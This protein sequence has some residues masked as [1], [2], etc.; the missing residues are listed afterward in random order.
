V[1]EDDR[2]HFPLYQAVIL[3][4][5]DLAQRAPEAVRAIERIEGKID[6]S[7]MIAMNAR[8]K[9]QK[10]SDVRVAQRFPRR[11]SVGWRRRQRAWVLGPIWDRTRTFGIGRVSLLA[12]ILCGGS[13]GVLAAQS[14][15]AGHVIMGIVAVRLHDSLAGA[16][17]VHASCARN[18]MAARGG[19]AVP[20]QPAADCPQHARGVRGIPLAVRESAATSGYRGGLG[21]A[22]RGA[23]GDRHRYSRAFN[24]GVLNVGTAT[25][26]ALIGAGGYGQPIVT[27]IRLDNQG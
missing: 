7:R 12:A 4:R 10:V 2:K 13:T 23:A 5:A 21:F 14:E 19:G 11:R 15:A 3:Y 1:L 24:F 6:Q 25:L 18:R 27:E 8:A 22:R 9:I 17:G 20:L 16:P 26:G